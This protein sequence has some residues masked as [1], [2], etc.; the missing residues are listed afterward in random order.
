MQLGVKPVQDR[1]GPDRTGL[2]RGPNKR[3]EVDRGPDLSETAPGPDRTGEHPDRTGLGSV[4]VEAWL[5]G[6]AAK[7]HGLPVP[8]GT[9]VPT[10]FS[11]NSLARPYAR[12]CHTCWFWIFDS[13]EPW[14]TSTSVQLST[15][16]PSSK[17]QNYNTYK[18]KY[19]SLKYKIP[20]FQHGN[21]ANIHSLQNHLIQMEVSSMELSKSQVSSQWRVEDAFGVTV[22]RCCTWR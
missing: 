15:P 16:T 20:T 10:S 21:I 5:T 2:D 7:W 17:I 3:G 1:T 6:L 18:Y 13:F 14:N 22:C 11:L 19:S 8:V 9:P 4:L 12:S